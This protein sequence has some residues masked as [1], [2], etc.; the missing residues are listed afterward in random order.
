MKNILTIHAAVEIVKLSEPDRIANLSL[1]VSKLK[2]ETCFSIERI[3]RAKQL[4][5][6]Q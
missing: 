6:V 2:K 3:T 5:R 1:L 4:N